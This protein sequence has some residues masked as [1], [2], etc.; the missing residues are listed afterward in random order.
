VSERRTVVY[1]AIAAN[2]AI[3]IT[4]FVAASLS[5]SSALF[6]EGLHSMVDTGDG[7][8][9]LLG[10]HLSH[11]PATRRHPYGHNGEIYFWS[12]IVAMSIFGIGGGLSIYEGIQH[13]VEPRA[14]GALIWSYSTLGAA[15]VFEGISWLISVRGFRRIHG[16]RGVWEAI[17]ASKDPTSFAVVLEDSAALI[18]IVLAATGIT[19]AHLLDQPAYDAAASILIGAL[20]VGVGGILGRETWSLLLGESASSEVV[21]SIRAIARAEPGVRDVGPRTLHLGPDLVH[22]DLD[23]E[24]EPGTDAIE[25]S[26]RIEAAVRGRHALVRRVSFRFP[27]PAPDPPRSSR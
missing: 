13:L 6:S 5:G 21:D 14:P 10:M 16:A 24:V 7:L 11:K 17:R 26:R 27:A 15:F 12:M 4:K 22:V 1:A 18:G 25:L 23:L 9:L 19:L 20:L 3:A 8:L 2:V